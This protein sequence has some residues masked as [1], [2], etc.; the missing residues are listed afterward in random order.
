MKKPIFNAH[1]AP[2]TTPPRFRVVERPIVTVHLQDPE[3]VAEITV[4]TDITPYEAYQI[5]NMMAWVTTNPQP[6]EDME[7]NRV[8]VHTLW[9]KYVLDNKLER[10]FK[11]SSAIPVTEPG[12]G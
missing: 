8:L 5:A 10:H 2:I 7:G 3:G 6:T 4:Q 11:F 1:G 9:R 12:H